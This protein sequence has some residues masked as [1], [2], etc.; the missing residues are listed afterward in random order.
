MPVLDLFSYRKR[1][2]E[3]GTPDVFVYDRLP[4]ALRVQ[5]IHIWTDAIGPFYVRASV[6]F[7]SPPPHNNQGWEFIHNSVVRE[8]GVFA[9][10]QEH[11]ISERCVSF[12]MESSSVDAAL[13]LIEASFLYIYR[14]ARDFGDYDRAKRGIKMTADAAIGELN[15]RFRRA[16]VGYQFD[17]GRI[18]RVDSELIHREVVRPVLRYL[19]RPGFEGPRDEFLQA[20]AHYR[21]GETKDAITD[22]NNAFESTLK[23]ICDQRRWQYGR[24]ARASDLLKVVRRNGLLPDYLDASFDQLVGTLKSGLPKVRNEAGAHGQ[25]AKPRETPDYVAAY[26]LHLAAAK[27]LFLVEAHGAMK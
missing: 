21:S 25:G 9:L 3:A 26:A 27:I 24:G 17:D 15:E 18:F 1:V 12:L 23:T 2:A 22:A 10:G 4:E 14:I 8:H 13:D 16:G 6:D 19:P 5:I 20:H 7:E 11:A